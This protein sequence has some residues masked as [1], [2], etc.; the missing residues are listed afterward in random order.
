[1]KASNNM[2]R[3]SDNR[4]AEK[5]LPVQSQA[6]AANIAEC[7]THD[8]I[9][10]RFMVLFDVISGYAGLVEAAHAFLCELSHPLKNY[11]FI[12]EGAKGYAI[13]H[14]HLL[15]SDPKGPQASQVLTDIFL[16]AAA[17]AKTVE[18]RADAM[19]G[20]ILFLQKLSGE[21]KEQFDSFAPVVKYGFSRILDLPDDQFFLAVSSF[22][23]VHKVVKAYVDAGGDT[24][25]ND[26]CS[27][28]LIRYFSGVFDYWLSQKDPKIWLEQASG[29][30]ITDER[31]AEL[32]Q[33]VSHAT[34]KEYRSTLDDVSK[35][36]DP[37]RLT[38]LLDLPGFGHWVSAYRNL[39]RRLAPATGSA[40]SDFNA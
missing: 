13:K 1:M 23:Q 36:K 24:L 31:R 40:P 28:L 29:S 15:K 39:A 27:R 10:Q 6:L 2:N 33:P 38:A 7:P 25:D 3:A 16:D 26:V 9:D 14:L 18:L 11:G 22:Y 37:E 17:N 5:D 34:T 30:P 12:L 8:S 20:L 4:Y 35:K 19:D 21:M 32:F